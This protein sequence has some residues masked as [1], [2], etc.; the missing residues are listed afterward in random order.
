MSHVLVMLT[1]L[2]KINIPTFNKTA[3]LLIAKTCSLDTL[4]STKSLQSD[5][6]H[7]MLHNLTPRMIGYLMSNVV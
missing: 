7:N 3:C 2:N 6:S 5:Q 1:E 4:V